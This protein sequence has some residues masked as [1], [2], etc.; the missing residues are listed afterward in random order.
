MGN[1]TTE[2]HFT[3]NVRGLQRS[4]DFVIDSG[5][6]A[7]MTN[8]IEWLTEVTECNVVITAAQNSTFIANKMGTLKCKVYDDQGRLTPL[9]L[10]G[11]LYSEH[12]AANLLSVPAA[13]VTACDYGCDMWMFEQVFVTPSGIRIPFDRSDGLYLLRSTSVSSNRTCTLPSAMLNRPTPWDS[14][15]PDAQESLNTVRREEVREQYA[16][17]TLTP[18][19][20][21][22]EH[23][24]HGH[25]SFRKLQHML[26][27]NCSGKWPTCPTCTTSNLKRSPYRK[28]QQQ[29]LRPNERIYSD[30]CGPFRQKGINGEQYINDYVDSHSDYIV[31]YAHQTK[32]VASRNFENYCERFGPPE[33]IITDQGGE[34]MSHEFKEIIEEERIEHYVA[35]TGESN[36][37]SKAERA[38]GVLGNLIRSN[39]KSSKLPYQ[40]WPY[41]LQHACYV[42]NRVPSKRNKW[43]TP[44]ELYWNRATP[45]LDRIQPFGCVAY[46]GVSKKKRRIQGGNISAKLGDR[47]KLAIYLGE[48]QNKRSQIFF[49]PEFVNG[50][51]SG[52]VVTSRN[53]KFLPNSRLPD[54]IMEIPGIGTNPTDTTYEELDDEEIINDIEDEIDFREPAI[55]QQ[56]QPSVIQEEVETEE[57]GEI[58][59]EGEEIDTEE[60]IPIDMQHEDIHEEGNELKNENNSDHP[61]TL[62]DFL[63]KPNNSR[64]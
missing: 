24:K 42:H 7:Y 19:R 33:T 11:V 12:L 56:H 61:L 38:W 35:E 43:K 40:M 18:E 45:S 49:V 34:F 47:G 55:I 1:L 8:R 41:A 13:C 9:T 46:I 10:K 26:G 52:Q 44:Y 64:N 60:D 21:L 39:M 59:S 25:V 31:V 30:L 14:P 4:F 22:Q 20:V 15:R 36:Q 51:M 16:G 17:I 28:V 2:E 3:A 50:K 48:A 62:S 37:N 27:F 32:D 54:V 29:A 23:I 63:E 58:Q 5:A 6:T 53:V 57:E